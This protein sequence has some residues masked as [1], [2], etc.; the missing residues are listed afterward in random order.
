[1][2][3]HM[4][5]FIVMVM[6]LVAAF[7]TTLAQEKAPDANGMAAVEGD[8]QRA[9]DLLARLTQSLWEKQGF[10]VGIR[11]LQQHRTE[12]LADYSQEEF[13]LAV[14]RPSQVA[15]LRQGVGRGSELIWNGKQILVLSAMSQEYELSVASNFED[16][17]QSRSV[18]RVLGQVPFIEFFLLRDIW[19]QFESQTTGWTHLGREEVDHV[20]CEHILF[21]WQDIDWHLWLEA[22][23]P[24]YLRQLKPDLNKALAKARAAQPQKQFPDTVL[25]WRFDSWQINPVYTP[26]QFAVK[27]PSGYRRAAQ[28][29]LEGRKAPDISLPLLD[30]GAF[31]LADH[32]GKNIVILDFWATWCGP[33]KR[34]MPMIN[35]V[36]KAFTD[37]QVVL[38]TI[39]SSDPEEK[40]RNYL[41]G[42]GLSINV[43][44]DTR[45][46]ASQAY[47]V[48]GIPFTVIVGRNGVI[49]RVHVGLGP[50]AETE[51]T[52]ELESLLSGGEMGEVVPS[53]SINVSCKEAVFTPKT[54]V[55]G[56]KVAFGCEVV[57]SGTEPIAPG[58]VILQ[59]R[60][61]EEVHWAGP[62]MDPIPAG[63]SI[64]YQVRPE[65]WYFEPLKAGIL[66]YKILVGPA[67][68]KGAAMDA[69]RSLA[70]VLAV[71]AP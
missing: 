28:N 25:I 45:Q 2:A 14:Q 10:S 54:A 66:N 67:S 17:L 32:R 62:V 6:G 42:A 49:Q 46:N 35:R 68:E 47:Q 69:N 24:G 26:N 4:R 71:S 58:A 44:L 16:L 39:N 33:C 70:G 7:S 30:D 31:E 21:T 22:G 8:P 64:T 37:R 65:Q 12:T 29:P 59:F 3:Q 9:K 51:L 36:A 5:L 18:G 20:A 55:V 52:G 43:A 41:K 1:M 40:I 11:A 60:I 61:G 19:T 63:A 13:T 50:N 53:A 27:V 48:Q 57:N 56:Q 23:A 38:Y 34:A 15:F